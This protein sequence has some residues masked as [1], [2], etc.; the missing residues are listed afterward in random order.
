MTTSEFNK[1]FGEI[2]GSDMSWDFTIEPTKIT[3][4]KDNVMVRTFD[5]KNTNEERSECRDIA[6]EQFKRIVL[7]H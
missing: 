2:A 6:I 1:Q 7:K 3:I 4:L 5:N